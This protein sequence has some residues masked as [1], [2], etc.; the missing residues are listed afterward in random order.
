MHALDIAGGVDQ[1][2][3][4]G[5]QLRRLPDSRDGGARGKSR[6]EPEPGPVMPRPRAA[7]CRRTP[8]LEQAEDRRQIVEFAEQRAGTATPAM[9]QAASRAHALIGEC[10]NS[11]RTIAHDP[12]PLTPE[13]ELDRQ[14][15]MVRAAPRKGAAPRRAHP[16]DRSRHRAAAGGLLR[17]RVSRRARGFA[18]RRI[19]VTASVPPSGAR[20][21]C[22]CRPPPRP[23]R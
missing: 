16:S 3:T 9:R 2:A 21:G 8:R 1:H 20:P 5:F 17:R 10:P 14:A 7:A 15:G 12:H 22:S 23:R 6:S 18:G 13:P 19:P 4:A 11:A